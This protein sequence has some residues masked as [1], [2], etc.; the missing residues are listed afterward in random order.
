MEV[1]HAGTTTKDGKVVTDGGRVLGVTAI[2]KDIPEAIQRVYQAVE[3]INFQ[4]AHYRKD[5][6]QRAVKRLGVE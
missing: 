1:F 4:G 5:I 2:G 6:A 3:S